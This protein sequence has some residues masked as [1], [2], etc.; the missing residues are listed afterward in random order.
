[1]NIFALDGNPTVAAKYHVDKHV[2]KMVLEYCQLL[3]TAH[4][5]IDGDMKTELSKNGRKVKRY[6]LG[7]ERDSIVY[8]A[9]HVNHP[10]G[11]WTRA[12]KSHYIW[13]TKLL[14]A[15]CK[16]YTYRYGKVH[17]SESEGLVD[18][19]CN[20]IPEGIDDHGIFRLPDPAMPDTSKVYNGGSID[21]IQSYRNYY[22][23]EKTRL[24]D[25]SG[26]IYGRKQPEWI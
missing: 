5:V 14:R 11:I 9:C 25:W 4:R 12:D 3:S 21:V 8:L 24:L 17:K 7:D 18:W 13:L 19:L 15:T 26:K 2:V 22:R 16:E 6:Y 23:Q 1:M 20:N 10:S